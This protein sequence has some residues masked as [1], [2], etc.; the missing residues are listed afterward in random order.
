[1]NGEWGHIDGDDGYCLVM[2]DNFVHYS[3]SN[4]SDSAA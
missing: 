2:V 3:I 1:M 4:K